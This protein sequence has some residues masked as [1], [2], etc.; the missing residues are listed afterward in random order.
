L[1]ALVV[2]LV[3]VLLV[4]LVVVVVVVVVLWRCILHGGCTE[5]QKWSGRVAVTRTT[6][7]GMN[8][9]SRRSWRMTGGNVEKVVEPDYR[10]S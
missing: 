8:D 3:V 4:L 5:G 9:Q 10:G 2:V 6:T 1:V 7:P